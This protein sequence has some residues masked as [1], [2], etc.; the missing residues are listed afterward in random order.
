MPVRGNDPGGPVISCCSSKVWSAKQV[1]PAFS[2]TGT[3]S[4][5]GW[6]LA[7]WVEVDEA[8]WTPWVRDGGFICSPR[9]RLRWG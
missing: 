2:S 3:L 6:E 4:I 7:E 9:H 5:V 8:Q 1:P